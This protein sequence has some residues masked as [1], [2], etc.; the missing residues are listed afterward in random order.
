MNEAPDV[1]DWQ[2]DFIA[3]NLLLEFRLRGID[4]AVAKG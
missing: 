4:S 3:T 2:Q 1:M